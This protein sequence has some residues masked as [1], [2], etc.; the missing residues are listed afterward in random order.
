MQQNNINPTRR[1]WCA[2][3]VYNNKGTVR[4]V[5]RECRSMLE[6]VVVVDDG[7]TDADLSGLLSG[8]DIK[9]IRHEKNLGKGRA[10][11]TASRYIEEQG[12]AYMITIDAD[13]QHIPV[14]INKFI[15]LL[16]DKAP[17]IIIGS[18]NF[19]TENVPP[20]SRFGRKFANFWLHVETGVH[21]D[22]CQSGFRA[23]PVKYLNRMKF[24]GSHYDFEAEVLA[25]AV[26]AGLSLKTV[27]IDVVYPEPEKRVSSF[28]PFLD[29]LRLT[30]THAMLIGSRLIPFRHKQLV[31][32]PKTD[33]RLLRH[34]GK[35]LMM[36]LKENATP[37][38]LAFSAAVGVFLA[39]LPLMFLHTFLILYVAARLNLNKIVAVNV[40]HLC[41]PPFVPALCIEIG[42][43]IRNGQ[44]LTNISYETVFTQFGDRLLEW[45]L[46]SLIIAPLGAVLIALITYFSAAL[47]KRQVAANS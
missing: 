6:N 30:H 35:F 13:G 25:R 7:R 43:F 36:L 38:G 24:R 4:E 37:A 47:I 18:R 11:L 14:D 22:D 9:I 27:N 16:D 39:V 29:N 3:P 23:Y 46:G 21:I 8:I 2:V 10:I 28:R 19:D 31:E 32:R 33:F 12:G 15:P 20:K 41:M 34:P 44:W 26:W 40:Q 42:F 17:G 1:I 45:L 5:V